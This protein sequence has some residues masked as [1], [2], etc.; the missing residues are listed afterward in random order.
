MDEKT[1]D[2]KDDN[3]EDAKTETEDTKDKVEKV[4]S[5]MEED[6]KELKDKDPN[7]G[8]PNKRRK[9]MS[10]VKSKGKNQEDEKE[11]AEIRTP[12]ID[13]PVRERKSV[14]RLV[15]SIERHAVKEFQIEKVLYFIWPFWNVWYVFRGL[16]LFLFVGNCRAVVLHLRIYPMVCYAF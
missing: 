13:R 1:E 7:E 3:T 14:E 15:A 10:V 12:I 8:K 9:R 2:A 6:D 4:D 16:I 11:E 5:Q